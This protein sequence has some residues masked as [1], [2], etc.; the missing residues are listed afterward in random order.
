MSQ[1]NTRNNSQSGIMDENAI[2]QLVSK[3]CQKIMS[4]LEKKIDKNFSKMNQNVDNLSEK[5]KEIMEPIK[6]NEKDMYILNN[7][8]DDLETY[9]RSK[10][11]R[12]D[13]LKEG[14]NE[15][16]VSIATDL[17]SNTM[18]IKCSNLDISNIYRLGKK[19]KINLEPLLLIL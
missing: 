10:M 19:I 9:Q 15:N 14:Y 6:T 18:K 16:L 11:L 8:L 7:K 2:E 1:K 4:R 3:V 17:I 12:F 13:G 5:I